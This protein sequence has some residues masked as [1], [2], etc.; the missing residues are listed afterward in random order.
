MHCCAKR[1]EILYDGFHAMTDA[2]PT[3]RCNPSYKVVGFLGP[4]QCFF[5]P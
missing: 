3:R 4:S 1:V 2:F 5:Q